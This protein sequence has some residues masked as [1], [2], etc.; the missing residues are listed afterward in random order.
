MVLE[1]FIGVMGTGVL[2]AMAAKAC[3]L[4]DVPYVM[5]DIPYD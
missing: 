4:G 3:L 5:V 1:R 2:I